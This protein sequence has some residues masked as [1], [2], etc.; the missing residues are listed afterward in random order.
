MFDSE[1][2]SGVLPLKFF[3][4]IQSN[5]PIICIGG[6]KYSEVKK[7]LNKINRGII[8]ENSERVYEFFSEKIFSNLQIDLTESNNFPYSYKSSSNQL[9][10][11]ILY[12]LDQNKLI[13]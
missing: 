12:H 6:K 4:Y 10:K 8:L 11:I 3:E 5:R 2:D 1:Y 13:K 9:E 7:I